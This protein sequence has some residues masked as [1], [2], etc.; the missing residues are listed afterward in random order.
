M[1]F[2]WW[3]RTRVPA[4]ASAARR[5]PGEEAYEARL[6]LVR[7]IAEPEDA[8]REVRG[9]RANAATHLGPTHPVT[10][11]A[12]FEE[13]G[14]AGQVEGPQA[15]VRLYYNLLEHAD[16][17]E[18]VSPVLYVDTQWNLGGSLL[19]AGETRSAVEVLEFA[20]ENARL[21]FG[22]NHGTTFETRLTHIIAL[23]GDGRPAEA[24]ELAEKLVRDA[25][26]VLGPDHPT[27]ADARFAVHHLNARLD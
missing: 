18:A 17:I 13:A 15:A 11:A 3:R 2:R 10:L 12:Q 19:D 1:P 26:R 4:H 8:L 24:L 9:L 21:F 27:T 5:E 7:D 22:R 23:D 6:R 14:R 20:I 16:A 25:E